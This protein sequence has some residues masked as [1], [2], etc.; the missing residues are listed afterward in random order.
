MA[1][2]AEQPKSSCLVVIRDG[3]LVGDW[4]WDGSSADSPVPDVWSVT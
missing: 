3:V 2:I 1:V 4:Y